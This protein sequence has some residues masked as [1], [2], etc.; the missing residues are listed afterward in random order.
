MTRNSHVC[1]IEG[2][3]GLRMPSA[4]RVASV[5]PQCRTRGTAFS[6]RHANYLFH[7]ISM[8]SNPGDDE[9]NI[10][11]NRAFSD[12]MRPYSAVARIST[13]RRRIAPRTRAGY[14]KYQRL[15][16]LKERY[17]PDNRFHL[18]QNIRPGEREASFPH[19]R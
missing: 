6:Q 17:D 19:R 14:A 8:W 7:Q 9:R 18:N 2:S 11:A 15:V 5:S 4:R 1:K 10:E 16:A 3:C 12:A 13:S